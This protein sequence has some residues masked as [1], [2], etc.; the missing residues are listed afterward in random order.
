MPF[1]FPRTPAIGGMKLIRIVDETGYAAFLRQAQERRE[2]HAACVLEA[3]QAARCTDGK[4]REMTDLLLHMTQGRQLQLHRERDGSMQVG[5]TMRYR[6]GVRIAD[7]V[8]QGRVDRLRPLEQ[9]TLRIAERMAASTDGT[10]YE[11]YWQLFSWLSEHAVYAN[12]Q[13]GQEGYARLVGASGALLSGKANCQGFAD[14]YWL[15]CTLNGL[16]VGYQCGHAGKGTHLW[17]VIRVDERWYAADVSRGSRIL[18]QSGVEEMRHAFI[19]NRQQCGA[20]G[21]RWEPQ[22]ETVEVAEA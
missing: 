11:R 1:Q 6:E 5:V 2:R 17:N 18:R 10:A 12:A 7:A 14:A 4:V 21:I 20:L 22:Y 8:R 9:E 19:M 15:L 13:P 16:A 3:S